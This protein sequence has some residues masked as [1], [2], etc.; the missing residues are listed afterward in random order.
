M[1]FKTLPILYSKFLSIPPF[2]LNLIVAAVCALA[3][4]MAL[5]G[6]YGFDLHPCELCLYQRVPF[7]LVILLG[8][9]GSIFVS[10]AKPALWLSTAALFINAGI[11]AFHS[12]VERK[13]WAGLSGCTSPDLSGSL[14]DLM[15]RIQNTAVTRCDEIP[16]DL[17]GLSMANYNVLLCGGLACLIIHYLLLK[18]AQ[19]HAE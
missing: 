4:I 11:A 15:A 16:W 14:D 12:G 8:L 9:I 1:N 17:F 7:A 5:I 19:R 10:S 6:Q 18:R 2:R 3:L 13:W